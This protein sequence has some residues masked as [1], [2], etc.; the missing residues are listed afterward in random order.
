MNRLLSAI[1]SAATMWLA[2]ESTRRRVNFRSTA[3]PTELRSSI[4]V[5]ASGIAIWHG[6][7]PLRA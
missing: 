4:Y 1:K 6:S 3:P 5:I 7:T 2:A